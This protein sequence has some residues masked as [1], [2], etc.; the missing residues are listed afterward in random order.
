M[1]DTDPP[2]RSMNHWTHHLIARIPAIIIILTFL[3][4][5]IASLLLLW[6]TRC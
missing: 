5:G 1:F 6:A 4:I 3:V 2:H